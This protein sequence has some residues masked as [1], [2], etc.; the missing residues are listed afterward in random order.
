[1]RTQTLGRGLKVSAVGLGCMG[2][3]HAYGAAMDDAEAIKLI[4]YAHEQG[5]T[6]FD[7]AETYGTP[8]DP[9]CNEVLVANAL[10]PIRD[11]VTIVTKFGIHFDFNHEPPYPLC[12]DSTPETIY[13]SCEGSLKRMG[14]DHIDLYFQHRMDPNVEPEIVAE[15]VGK[16][17]KEGKVLHWGISEATEDYL[18]RAHAV[19]PVTAVENRYSMMA[20]EHESLWSTLEELGIGFLAFSPLAN[21]FLT[22]QVKK[23]MQAGFD[24]KAGDYRANMPQFK[25]ENI[26]KSQALLDMLNDTAAAHGISV[27]QLSL[28]WMICKKP[29]LVPIPG[30]RKAERIEQNAAAGDVVLSAEEIAR[31][32]AALD[33]M[34]FEVFGVHAAA[35]K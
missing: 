19:T 28:A 35:K 8:E 23:G 21:G 13:K 25:D 30:S 9:H 24:G 22:G 17:I 20:R 29:W 11:E 33:G 15:A 2:F 34:E 31:I 1:M 3:S 26:E 14:L 12:L 10:R 6:L 4:R 5:V 18:R 7:S 32:D 16:L 27:P